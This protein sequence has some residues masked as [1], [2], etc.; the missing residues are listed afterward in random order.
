[1]AN[2]EVT[3][4]GEALVDFVSSSPTRSLSTATGFVKAAG[5]APANVAV[6]LSRLGIRTEFVGTVGADSFGRFLTDELRRFGVGT[7][8]IVATDEGK[9]RLAFVAVSKTGERDFEFWERHPAGQQLHRKDIDVQRVVRSKIVNIGPFLLLTKPARTTAYAVAREAIRRG[10][11]VC[12]DPNL[13]MSLWREPAEVKR[14]ALRMMRMT[15]VLRMNDEEARFFT[16]ARNVRSAIRDLL[17]LGPR[18]VVITEGARGCTFATEDG[19]RRLKGF[20]VR[21]VDTT[22]CGDGF[23]AGLLA[24]IVRS[25]VPVGRFSV[26]ELAEVCR[27]ANAVG[28]LVSLKRGAIPAMPSE[29]D[30]VGFLRAQS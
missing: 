12:F 17:G 8:G 19:I 24:G 2:A 28:A 27:T 29:E 13:R 1:M 4:V 7:R 21:A 6:G 20:R 16:G 18:I 5:G 9:T 3:C 25:K 26:S 14:L 10:S 22:G 23:L 15:T 30:V 11:S